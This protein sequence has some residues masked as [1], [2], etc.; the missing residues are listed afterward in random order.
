MSEK[1]LFGENYILAFNSGIASRLV[2]NRNRNLGTMLASERSVFY[3]H[4]ILRML[5]F[6]REH[7]IEPLNDEIY[8]AV[9]TAQ[10]VYSSEEYSQEIFNRDI[11]QLLDWNIISRRIEKERLRGYRDISRQKFRFFLT[12]ETV[13]FIVW[14]EESYHNDIEEKVTDSRN[15]LVDLT[16]RLKETVRGL[17]RIEKNEYLDTESKIQDAANIIYSI[18]LLDDLTFKISTQLG[19]LN[20]R[21]LSFLFANYNLQE[22]K[23]AISELEFYTT[24]YLKQVDKLRREIIEHI[25]KI[26]DNKNVSNLLELCLELALEYYSKLPFMS[27]KKILKQSAVKTFESLENFYKTS[28]KLDQLC[29]R[30]NDTA[31]KVWS[32]LS[33]YLRE[34]ERKN[35]RLEDLKARIVEMSK[36]DEMSSM[37]NFFFELLALSQMVTDSNYWKEGFEKADPP[38]PRLINE[39]TIK[40]PKHY[41]KIRNKGESKPVQ[42]LEQFKIEKLK[43]WIESKCIKAENFQTLVSECNFDEFSDFSKIL[44]LAES[45]ILNNG[46]KIKQNR[47]EARSSEQF[48]GN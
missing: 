31:M 45:G 42:S 6:R 3:V 40:E 30:I 46:K 47:Y 22:A 1:S 25:K 2:L 35:T 44:E 17:Q 24:S 33:A 36:M 38:I 43:Q 5:Y 23:N 29:R 21:L 9:K 37:E 8:I 20:A 4:I 14:L 12:D 7:E 26:I 39:K 48:C 27:K 34:L 10:E 16:G 13:S 18:N 15:F 32:K 41:F 28:G 19:E 11:Q